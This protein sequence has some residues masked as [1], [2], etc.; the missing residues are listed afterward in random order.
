MYE[1]SFLILVIPTEK[2]SNCVISTF[3]IY[4]VVNLLTNNPTICNSQYRKVSRAVFVVVQMMKEHNSVY[5][6]H[7]LI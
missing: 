5:L 4:N 2:Y 6:Y 7:K 3:L 1:Y